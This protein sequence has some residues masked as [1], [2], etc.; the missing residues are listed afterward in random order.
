MRLV[1]LVGA[2]AVVGVGTQVRASLV[3]GRWKRPAVDDSR[4]DGQLGHIGRQVVHDPM[5]PSGR[6]VV[7][8]HV[9]QCD[10]KTLRSLG[11]TAP[12][13]RWRLIFAR[14]AEVVESVC[15]RELCR[16]ERGIPALQRETSFGGEA[17]IGHSECG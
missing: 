10:Y 5:P 13:Q 6:R 12:S 2:W 8:V 11:R 3:S 15:V 7:L 16:T 1:A 17:D 14:A 9:E 4:T